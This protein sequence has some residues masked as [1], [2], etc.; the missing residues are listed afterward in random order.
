MSSRRFAAMTASGQPAGCGIVSS[1][2]ARL[3]LADF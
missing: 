1:E 3:Y 2:L